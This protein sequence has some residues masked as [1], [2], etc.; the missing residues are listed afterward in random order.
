MASVRSDKRPLFL[1]AGCDDWRDVLTR[2]LR[3]PACVTRLE[4]KPDAGVG[5][6][7][8]GDAVFLG[9]LPR[10]TLYR[11]PMREFADKQAVVS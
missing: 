4:L 1:P 6:T 7:A 2:Q 9:E 3:D 8:I 5:L 11:M 10:Q